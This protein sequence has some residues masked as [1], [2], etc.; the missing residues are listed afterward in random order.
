MPSKRIRFCEMSSMSGNNG[1]VPIQSMAKPT[2][3]PHPADVEPHQIHV[4]G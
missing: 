2:N 4:T 1:G 3:E